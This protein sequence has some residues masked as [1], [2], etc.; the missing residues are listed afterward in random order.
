ML[1]NINDFDK[2]VV[3]QYYILRYTTGKSPSSNQDDAFYGNGGWQFGS[4]A[5][6]GS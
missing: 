6:M 4:H 1:L 3:L 2:T 5:C